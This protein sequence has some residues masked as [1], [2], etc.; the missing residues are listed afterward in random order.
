M[1]CQVTALFYEWDDMEAAVDGL[2]ARDIAPDDLSIML[3]DSTAQNYLDRQKSTAKREGCEPRGTLGQLAANLVMAAGSPSILG[4]GPMMRALAA[5]GTHAS[6]GG[7]GAGLCGL[8][9]A[10]DEAAYYEYS[11]R[12]RDAL[13]LGVA[14]AKHRAGDV[15]AFL[16]QFVPAGARRSLASIA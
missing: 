1:S 12:T 7:V 13:L 4:S 6:I 14:T 16:Q 3:N 10:E 15:R 5:R 11:I 2:V 8:G 9:L